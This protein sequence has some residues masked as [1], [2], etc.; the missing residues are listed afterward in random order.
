[1]RISISMEFVCF[2]TFERQYVHHLMLPYFRKG[3]KE[4]QMIERENSCVWF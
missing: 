3:Q 1:M 2:S 4:M